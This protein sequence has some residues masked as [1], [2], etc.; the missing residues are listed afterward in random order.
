[1][2]IFSGVPKSAATAYSISFLI[3]GFLA[4]NPTSP[5]LD[6]L[7]RAVGDDFQV[8]AREVSE[9]QYHNR[10]AAVHFSEWALWLDGRSWELFRPK[11]ATPGPASPGSDIREPRLLPM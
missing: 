1:M 6:L 10:G 7:S 8:G 11:H 5:G 2:Q 9:S 3:I 4:A